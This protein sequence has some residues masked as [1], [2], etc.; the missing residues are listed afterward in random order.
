MVDSARQFA[1]I[2]AL[3][4]LTEPRFLDIPDRILSSFP[5]RTIGYRP[6][7]G[8]PRDNTGRSFDALGVAVKGA[9]YVF[10]ALLAPARMSRLVELSRRDKGVPSLDSVLD[11]LTGSVFRN[12]REPERHAEIRR[13]VR[14]SLVTKL[15]ALS[16]KK[17]VS[18]SARARVDIHLAEL[19]ERLSKSQD[20]HSLWLAGKIR[21]QLERPF[22]S[23]K[24]MASKNPRGRRAH[25][26][27]LDM[28]ADL[29][30]NEPSV[31][32]TDSA[33]TWSD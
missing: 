16:L 25:D 8:S 15:L 28:D 31:S 17:E 5:P 19:L 20:R 13:A 1:A 33:I 26:D 27:H 6:E 12:A 4:A 21:R 29:W 23:G 24:I 14:Q 22:G 10:N 18:D 2:K 11:A 9:A 30:D 3:V 7:R 32:F